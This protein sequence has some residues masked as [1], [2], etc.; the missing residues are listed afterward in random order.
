MSDLNLIQ[1]ILVVGVAFLAGMEGILDEFQFHQPLVACTLIGLVTGNLESG[2][3]L[4]GSLQMIALGWANIGAAVAPDA[5]LASVAAAIILV[6]GG[7][8]AS[9]IPSAIAVAIPLAVAGLF[10]TMIVRTL[11]V[12]IVQMMDRAAEKGNFRQI[13]GLQIL[14]ICMQ[15]VRIAIPAAA[16]MAVSAESVQS[17]LQSMPAWL[18]EGMAIGGGMVVAVGYALVINMMAN[19]EVWP[20]FILGFVLAAISELTLIGIGAIGMA[21]VFIYLNLSKKGSSSTGGG[22]GNSNDPLGDILNDY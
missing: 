16:I 13:E 1:M 17:A 19:K 4:G 5:A 10:L 2:I 8:G 7:Q 22:G 11:A 6:K 20:F 15:G 14:A 21:L 18:T 9:G 12:P 3:I